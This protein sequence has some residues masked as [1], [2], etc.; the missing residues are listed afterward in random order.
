MIQQISIEN[1]RG[2]TLRGVLNLPQACDEGCRVPVWMNIHGFGGNKC[3]YKN[4][5]VQQARKLEKN[6][7]AGVRFDFFGNGESDGEFDEMTFTSLLEDAED[8]FAWIKEQPWADTNHLILSGQSM[9]GYVA[10]TVAPRLQ[11]EK[12]I[13]QCPGAAM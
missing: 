6:G 3:G 11:P 2:N 7:I 13:L 8:I 9:G 10:S 12:L 1:R 5:Y 4:L